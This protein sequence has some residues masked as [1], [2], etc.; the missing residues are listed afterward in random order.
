MSSARPSDPL[1]T[2]VQFLKG[3]GPKGAMLLHKLGLKTVEDVLWHFPRRYQDR[4]NLP[5]LTMLRP[6][7][8]ATVRGEL[9][10]V[11][12]R[13][14]RGGRVLISATLADRTGEVTLTWFN[15]PWVARELNRQRGEIIAFGMV[16][17]GHRHQLEMSGPEW[18]WI[19]P[20]D[21]ADEFARLVPV[22]PLSE[23]V[24]QSVVRRAA[25]SAVTFFAESMPDALPVWLRKAERLR[26]IAWCLQQMHLPDTLKEQEEGRRRLVFE[27]FYLLQLVLQL[28]RQEAHKE[29]GISFPIS[30]LG[31]NRAASPHLFDAPSVLDE[32][33][34]LADEVAHMLP[35]ELT[36]AQKR[37][38]Q[39]IWE[40][41]ERPMPMNRL[42]QGDVGSG[43]TAVAAC[44]ML[45]AVRC[46]YQAAL[47]A[48]TEILAEQHAINLKRLFEPLGIRVGLIVGKQT[49]AIKRRQAQLTQTGDIQIAVGTHALIQEG[50]K[51]HRLGLAVVD[52]Q[53]R[54]GVRQR[55]AL[56]NKAVGNPDVLVMT[57]TPIPRTLTMTLYGDLDLSVIDELPP[58]RKPIKTHWK[59]PSDRPAVYQAVRKLIDEG[60]QAYF[61]CPMISENE[62]VQA[63]AAQDL[64]Y[65]L[66]QEVYPDLRLGL[67]HGQMK[68]VEKEEMM[69]RFRAH[70][71]DILVSTVVIEVGVDVPNASVMVIEDANR[72]GLSQLHQLRGRV[73]RGGHQSYCILV[74]DAT[75]DDARERMEIMV[76]TTDGFRIAEKDLQIRGPGDIAG[77]RQSGA[78]DL[79][80]ANLVTD[81]RLLEVARHAALQT[82]ER[83]PL[84]NQ[85]E[86][87]LILNKISMQRDESA[88]ITVT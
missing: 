82:L 3:V 51:F 8:E 25:H 84:L 16:K 19:D 56:R 67:L 41:M 2:D 35:F 49:A 4:R 83:D 79:R 29:V 63:Q 58:G 81:G 36:G 50:V 43:K 37:V 39:E 74:A 42:V 80:V 76:E 10:E 28:K 40:D 71:I 59:R 7:M 32:G 12:T 24:P 20:E 34:T 54:F 6:G 53:H 69:A 68:G 60:R 78:L 77:T 85:E 13:P 55:L 26:G 70:E 23:G 52:E 44:A 73:G 17:E 14:I 15:Q 18:E 65:R 62:K 47:M 48:P 72:F 87:V 33:G 75:S 5:P 66:S 88:L 27:E 46:G 61:V 30:Q 57:A 11:K 21:E 1:A 86:H 22:Y 38:V 45:A 31:G 64:H 9:V